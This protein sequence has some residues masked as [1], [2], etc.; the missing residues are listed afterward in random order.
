ML[1]ASLLQGEKGVVVFL[2]PVFPTVFQ[3]VLKVLL[4]SN[5]FYSLPL[6]YTDECEEAEMEKKTVA[7]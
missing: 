5:D 4:I 2:L 6:F 3:G 1:V 7:N